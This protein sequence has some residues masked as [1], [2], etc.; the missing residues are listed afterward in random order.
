[1][2]ASELEEL[3]STKEQLID[4]AKHK[5]KIQYEAMQKEY[6]KA[7]TDLEETKTK[8]KD[9]IRMMKNVAA[10]KSRV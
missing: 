6:D 7:S 3:I 9:T 8:I 5:F 4:D 1:M 10:Y 2:S